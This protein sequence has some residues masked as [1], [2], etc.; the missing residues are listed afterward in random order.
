MPADTTPTSVRVLRNA[1]VLVLALALPLFLVAGW[2]ILGWVTGAGVWALQ[3]VISG[4]AVRKAESSDDPRTKVGLLAGSMI[5]RGWLVAGIIFAVGLG[6]NDAGLSAAVLFL[7]VFTLQ[8]TM[9]LA[10]RP[11]EPKR[12]AR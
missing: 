9:T 6:N 7:A 4:L 11:F 3:R 2:P 10:M 12:P 1:D 8:F 5:G